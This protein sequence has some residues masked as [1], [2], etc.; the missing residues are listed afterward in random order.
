LPTPVRRVTLDISI[1][2]SGYLLIFA[3][4]EDPNFGNDYWF[5]N[6]A[7]AEATAAEWFGIGPG[8]WQDS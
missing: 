5:E 7:D 2:A 3:A 1:E 6:L 4:R 8:R